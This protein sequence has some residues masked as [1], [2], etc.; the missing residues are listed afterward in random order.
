[1]DPCALH[2]GIGSRE[3]ARSVRLVLG[4]HAVVH[5][6][7]R[8]PLLAHSVHHAILELSNISTLIGPR[9]LA[10]AAWLILFELTLVYFAGVREVVLSGSVEHT[11][12]ELSLIRAAF[13][14]E[15]AH[16]GLF[17]VDE[18]AFVFDLIVVPVFGS[19]A[20]LLV[21]FPLTLVEA[22]LCIAKSSLTMSHSV[23]PL[24]LIDVAVCVRHAAISIELSVYCLTLV[25][26]TVWILNGSNA[27]PSLLA[28]SVRV[29]SLWFLPLP[30][31]CTTFSDILM[32]V[33]P[34]QTLLLGFPQ[35]LLQGV[36]RD[37]HFLGVNGPRLTLS[38]ARSSQI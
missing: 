34:N 23:L 19:F 22:A 31:I 17:A 38:E 6:S 37:H 3:G 15:S 21:L 16:A 1:M 36:L 10:H 27:R 12:K 11:I 33:V 26:S 7:V 5:V 29:I 20:V 9:H 18:V 8:V 4:P 32:V 13:A 2:R 25:H 28:P 30:K 24:A 14:S 35:D